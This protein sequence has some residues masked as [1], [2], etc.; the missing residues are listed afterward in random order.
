[1]T[2]LAEFKQDQN[3][4]RTV[5]QES[6]LSDANDLKRIITQIRNNRTKLKAIDFWLRY[7]E[8]IAYKKINGPLPVEWE[9]ETFEK[10]EPPYRRQGGGLDTWLNYRWKK[11]PF[12]KKLSSL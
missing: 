10:Y 5:I 3:Q 1:M 6:N 12:K 11:K 8:P 2:S 7:L 4:L 9:T